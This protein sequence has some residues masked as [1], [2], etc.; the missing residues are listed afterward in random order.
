MRYK[1][2]VSMPIEA[3]DGF[4]SEVARADGLVPKSLGIHRVSLDGHTAFFEAELDGSGPMWPWT[5]TWLDRNLP[6]HKGRLQLHN[7]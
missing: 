2:T 7:L 1:I 5:M 6:R 4:G 3:S